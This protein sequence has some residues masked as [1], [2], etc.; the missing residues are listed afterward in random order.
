MHPRIQTYQFSRT[1]AVRY[2]HAIVLNEEVHAT[3]TMSEEARAQAVEMRQCFVTAAGE[4]QALANTY[5]DWANGRDT[6]SW[7]E[8]VFADKAACTKLN[9]LPWTELAPLSP[10]TRSDVT[11]DLEARTVEDGFR[12][13]RTNRS[14]QLG[15]DLLAALAGAFSV[16]QER[17]R[18]AR[19]L[20][21]HEGIH[22]RHR[23]TPATSVQIGLFP[24]IV[25]E[26]DY[27]ADVWAMLHEYRLAKQN[28]G[29]F[30]TRKF[31]L[32]QIRVLTRTL[33]AFDAGAGPLY[34]IQVRRLNR[35]LTWY[36]QFLRLEGMRDLVGVAGVLAHRPL[37]EIAGPRVVARGSRVFYLLDP[38]HV[39]RPELAVLHD[40]AVHRLGEAGSLPLTELLDGLRARDGERVK[41][42]LRGAFDQL[43]ILS[44]PGRAR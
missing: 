12:F 43:K 32:D 24:K 26:V 6:Q 15:D 35:Y 19:M 18:A 22:E 25:E 4:L 33:W 10:D 7:L 39:Q 17:L 38:R 42:V 36:W 37:L 34:E 27:Q 41:E 16:D 2:R 30:D 29:Q 23:L 3:I 9:A 1:A 14:W 11:V 21:L 28:A 31:F 5:V 44:A 40:N 20:L 8:F 13:D